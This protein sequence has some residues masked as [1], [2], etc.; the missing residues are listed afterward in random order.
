MKIQ[1]RNSVF[2]TNS[3]STH[4]IAIKKQEES[5]KIPKTFTVHFRPEDYYELECDMA[6]PQDRADW[7]YTLL[8]ASQFGY[9]KVR[10]LKDLLKAH[11]VDFLIEEAPED[12][13]D[14]MFADVSADIEFFAKNLLR[15]P[16]KLMRFIFSP[17]TK[18][19]YTDRDYEPEMDRIHALE[20]SGKYDMYMRYDL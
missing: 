12:V 7:L 8:T 20:Q 15:D 16:D 9:F 18:S 5:V 6:T 1:R 4:A 11:G 13:P 19:I 3:S 14:D 2:E 10:K 17:D